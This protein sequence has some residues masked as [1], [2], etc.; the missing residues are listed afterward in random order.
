MTEVL[1]PPHNP[2]SLVMMMPTDRRGCR[3]ESRGCCC[4]LSW[5]RNSRTMFQ[6]VC[7]Y[8]REEIRALHRVPHFCCRNR[9]H[10]AGHLTRV[11]G[12]FDPPFKIVKAVHG[13][14]DE[15]FFE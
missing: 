1:K 3:T 2:R 10:G 7:E 15:S 5:L 13:L 11:F 14:C 9:L 8:A 4:E 12:R 6:I